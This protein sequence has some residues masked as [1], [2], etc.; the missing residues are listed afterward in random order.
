MIRTILADVLLG[1][2][3]LTVLGCS[4]GIVVMRDVYQKLHYIAPLGTVAPVLVG[5][6]VLI[7]SGWSANG[8]QTWLAIVFIVVSAPFLGHATGRAAMIREAGD[9]RNAVRSSDGER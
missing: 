1:A 7:Q 8:L 2:A 3:V 4:A 5:L 9:W 6:A